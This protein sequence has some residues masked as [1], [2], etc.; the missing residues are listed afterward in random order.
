MLF[1][2]EEEASAIYE[3]IQ[4]A[5]V[6]TAIPL[7]DMHLSTVCRLCCQVGDVV[8]SS[9][10]LQFPHASKT[11]Q[12]AICRLRK[13][14]LL[15]VLG[16]DVFDF[17]KCLIFGGCINDALKTGAFPH[18]ID[19]ALLN[20]SWEILAHVL[21]QRL[22]E[23]KMAFSVTETGFTFTVAVLTN[24]NLASIFSTNETLASIFS[25]NENLADEKGRDDE[26]EK[27]YK[28]KVVFQ[29]SKQTY[30]SKEALLGTVDLGPGALV[31]DGHAI[32]T[33]AMGA[34]SILRN[35]MC[36]L[37]GRKP[38]AYLKRIQKYYEEGFD[39][40]L[41]GSGCGKRK[42]FNLILGPTYLMFTKRSSG[43][44]YK[45]SWHSLTNDVETNFTAGGILNKS[46]LENGYFEGNDLTVAG[47]YPSFVEHNVKTALEAYA[48]QQEGNEDACRY[49]RR[50]LVTM[51][52]C[53]ES[54]AH[55]IKE[56][57]EMAKV[58]I[59]REILET[60][61]LHYLHP[62]LETREEIG[63][64]EGVC[65]YLGEVL[66]QTIMKDLELPTVE[67]I[68]PCHVFQIAERALVHLTPFFDIP[69]VSPAENLYACRTL[70]DMQIFHDEDDDEISSSS[71]SIRSD[72]GSVEA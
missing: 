54:R 70:K 64:C 50:F 68:R 34:L 33:N 37:P 39:L 44:G 22:E 7:T 19:I 23:L 16:R 31:Y 43:G 46:A 5:N 6:E 4:N 69:K 30:T 49:A 53:G 25:T 12:E 63:L 20:S 61:C 1:L 51:R 42:T 67:A 24:E 32:Y 14:A 21:T 38:L 29:I 52:F 40:L 10:K 55:H 17:S 56:Y 3:Q 28:N 41:P 35:A 11:I 8:Q 62:H 48:L 36:H 27:R 65:P 45:A 15:D 66:L 58:V 72:D 9:A 26:K 18:D 60:F 13:F 2:E 57:P 47:L 71:N 59:M